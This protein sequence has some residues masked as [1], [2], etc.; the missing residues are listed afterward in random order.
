M[1]GVRH[2]K[3]FEKGECIMQYLLLSSN[4]SQRLS[5]KVNSY[6]KKGWKLYGSPAMATRTNFTGYCQ[7]IIYEGEDK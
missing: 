5:E 7:A 4:D 2:L 3:K 1:G 6:L